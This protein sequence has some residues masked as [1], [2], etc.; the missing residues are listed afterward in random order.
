[1]QLFSRILVALVLIGTSTTVFADQYTDIFSAFKNV[2]R[3][4]AQSII[5]PTLVA[6]PVEIDVTDSNVR[7]LYEEKTDSFIPHRVEEIY[8]IEPL[9]MRVSSGNA[10]D[11]ALTDNNIQTGATFDITENPQNAVFI[12]MRFDE[13][14]TSSSFELELDRYVSLPTT[15]SIT[16][17]LDGYSRVIVAE[18]PMTDTQIFFPQATASEWVVRLTY[19]QPLRLSEVRLSQDAAEMSVQ[20]HIVFL[21]QPESRYRLY[22]NADRYVAVQTIEAGSFANLREA[23]RILP[24]PIEMNAMYTESDTDRDMIPD[25]RDNCVQVANPDQTDIDKNGRGDLCDDYDGDGRTQ[26]QDNCPMVANAGQSDE[27]GDGIGDA[28]DSEESRLTEQYTW[29]PWAGM[30]IAVLVLIILTILVAMNPKRPEE[31]P[32]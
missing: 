3:I 32:Q 26:S 17:S 19:A 20:R 23:R 24:A 15:I 13:P 22:F 8:T 1:M 11:W 21:A 10:N 29:V 25:L 18:R 7:A 30:G 12:T 14:V 2:H 6:L 31:I 4:E 5:V 27:D 16:G 9:P 28:C